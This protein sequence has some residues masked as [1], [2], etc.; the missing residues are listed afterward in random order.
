MTHLGGFFIKRKLDT[1]DRKDVLY[2][3]CLHEVSS[4]LHAREGGEGGGRGGE[5]GRGGKGGFIFT[6]YCSTWSVCCMQGRI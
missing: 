5:E 2:R 1:S 4:S 6:L 3:S